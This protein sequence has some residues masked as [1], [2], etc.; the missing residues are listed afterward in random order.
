MFV[1][2]YL[3]YNQIR[4]FKPRHAS[5]PGIGSHATSTSSSRIPNEFD[6][7]RLSI[8]SSEKHLNES[9]QPPLTAFINR[10]NY[11]IKNF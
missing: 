7:Y 2:V 6:G 5:S 10:V 4:G 1:I 3:V 11:F 9:N 8:G